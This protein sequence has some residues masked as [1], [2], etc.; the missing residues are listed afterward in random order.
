VT[1]PWGF[2]D[3]YEVELSDADSERVDGD[4]VAVWVTVRA[5]AE[6]SDFSA[7]VRAPIVISQGQAAA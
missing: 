6:L 1:D 7:N 4:D 5:G 2:F 3:D